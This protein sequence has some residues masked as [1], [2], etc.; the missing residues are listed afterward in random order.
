MI[1]FWIRREEKKLEMLR[2][3]ERKR[4]KLERRDKRKHDHCK[5]VLNALE[6]IVYLVGYFYNSLTKHYESTIV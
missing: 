3:K 5:Q 4:F 1:I 6:K 2:R